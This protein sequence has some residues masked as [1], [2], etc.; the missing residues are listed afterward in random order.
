M[1]N[2][3][4]YLTLCACLFALCLLLLASGFPAS[5]QQPR[6][7]SWIG[8]LSTRDPAS[9]SSRA[10]GVRQG[11]RELGYTV[12]LTFCL[13]LR[14]TFSSGLKTPFSY[15]A[16]M[17]LAINHLAGSRV[18]HES[19]SID[20]SRFC[21]IQ[22]SD[23]GQTVEKKDRETYRS[24]ESNKSVGRCGRKGKSAAALGDQLSVRPTETN[25]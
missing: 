1:R 13:F 22:R 14:R 20:R 7:V 5:A 21:Q 6:K 24:Y 25:Q 4:S 3:I 10:E 16:L 11:L 8:Y 12:S 17:A 19:K 15:I 2:S 18:M 23:N 9:D